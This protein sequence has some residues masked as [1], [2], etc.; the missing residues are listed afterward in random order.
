MYNVALYGKRYNDT[1]LEVETI[2]LGETNCGL[3]HYKKTGGIYNM[4]NNNIKNITFNVFEDGLK[5]AFIISERERSERSSVVYDVNPSDVSENTI[6]TINKNCDWMHIC[7]LDDIENY[8]NFKNIDIKYSID[9]CTTTD[10]SKFL[11]LME[12]ASVIFD[13][14]ER[15]LLYADINIDTPII[16]H[17]KNGI[18][19]VVKN[20][21]IYNEKLQPIKNLNVNGAGD[22]YASIF[23][24][25]HINNDIITAAS[26]AMKRTKL[27][28]Q[29]LK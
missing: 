14:H 7:Y 12:S 17:D 22:L 9:F 24:S 5:K 26:N 6:N 8:K 15:K 21:T 11:S 29:E 16:L 19:I 27:Y 3:A 23:I 4:L 18:S 10:R 20:K 25:E 1:I 13:S 28:L 2:N